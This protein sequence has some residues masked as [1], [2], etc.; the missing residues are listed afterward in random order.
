MRDHSSKS[1]DGRPGKR[2][3]MV[4]RTLMLSVMILA[5]TTGSLSAADQLTKNYFTNAIGCIL[6][7]DLAGK[8]TVFINEHLADARH[9]PVQ[10]FQIPHALLALETGVCKDENA[11]EKWEGEFSHIPSWSMNHTLASALRNSVTWYFHRT[12]KKIG[13]ERMREFLQNIE[14]GNAEL[15][16]GAAPW[17]AHSL[18]ISPREQLRF[19]KKLYSDELPVKPEVMAAVRS[20]L[21]CEDAIITYAMG[22]Y[23]II[24]DVSEVKFSAKTG[25]R[26]KPSDTTSWLVGY[27]EK[28]DL[29]AVFCCC[30]CPVDRPLKPLTATKA[31]NEFLLDRGLVR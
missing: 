16:D 8:Q 5:G 20:M 30:G 7:E 14:Y 15:G 9:E 23:Q 31:F 27:L 22:T 17:M 1:E 2:R 18:V 21:R 4:I 3:Y 13:R 28:E 24:G 26:N 25:F 29:K 10:T 19:M 11:L 12:Y 6:F